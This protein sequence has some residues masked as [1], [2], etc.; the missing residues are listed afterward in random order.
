L[1]EYEKKFADY[2]KSKELF[3]EPLYFEGSTHSVA[4]AAN[5]AGCTAEDLVKNICLLTR[6]GGL[7]VAV[8]R[9]DLRLDKAKLEQLVGERLSFCPVEQVLEKTGYPA[10]GVPSL[11][12]NGR[13][14][15]DL[16]VVERGVVLCGGGSSK[17]LARVRASDVVGDSGAVVAD[18]VKR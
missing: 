4:E 8:L 18:L 15:V 6:S 5:V 3:F 7:V 13:V 1:D 12:L 11:G 9:G 14:F 16:L 10:G 2:C 17:S